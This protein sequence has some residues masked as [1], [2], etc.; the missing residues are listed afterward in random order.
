MY[1]NNQSEDPN[2][3]LFETGFR[4]GPFAVIT[5]VILIFGGMGQ[6]LDAQLGQNQ[7]EAVEL[8]NGMRIIGRIGSL[9]E[10]GATNVSVSSQSTSYGIVLVEDEL[11]DTFFSR[12]NVANI[13]P[14]DRQETK[15]EIWQHVHE[16][17]ANNTAVG[18]IMG[19]GAFDKFGR[20]TITTMT[21]RGPETVLQGI[22][23]ISPRYV[24]LEGLVN[25]GEGREEQWDMR[26]AL[27]SVPVQV[28]EDV[29]HLQIKDRD[30]ANERMRLVDFFAQAQKFSHAERELMAIRRDFPGLRQ[31]L[32]KRSELL[33]GQVARQM[34][35]EA[36]LRAD[37]GQTGIAGQLIAPLL[38][39]TDLSG[40]VLA[41]VFQTRD[42]LLAEVAG[43]DTARQQVID[44][45]TRAFAGNEIAGD[46]RV[47][48]ETVVDEIK[49]TLRSTNL[50]RLAT[51]ARLADDP[52][53][54]DSQKLSLAITGWIVGAG[55][56]NDNP[57]VAQSLVQARTLVAEY[58]QTTRSD[59]R[60]E[61][62]A[63]LET[64]ES[65]A[66]K[67]I[68]LI[69][70]HILPPLAP[71][72]SETTSD[73]PM[74]INI[75]FG[76]PPMKASYLIQLPPE[77][78][79]W[80]NYPCIVTLG[81]STDSQTTPE[82]QIDW[83]C[84][85]MLERFGIRNGHASRHGYIVIAPRWT[86]PSQLS[87]EYSQKE[88]AIVLK[89]L[90][91]AMR[92][93]SIDP[94]RV[95]LTGH[96]DGGTAAWDIGQSHPEHWAGVI[97]I[98][99]RAGKYIN[100]TFEN[101]KLH[102]SWYFINGGRDFISRDLNANVWNKRM[103]TREYQT[104]IVLIRGRGAEKFGDELPNLFQWMSV[105]RR[106]PAIETFECST[107]R[108]WNNNFWWLELDL[109]DNPKMVAPE[110]N[111]DVATKDDWSV[112][113]ERKI[114]QNTLK[115]RGIRSNTAAAVWMSPEIVDFAK[116]IKIENVGRNFSG[117]VKPSR[118]IILEDARTRGDRQHAWWARVRY[119]NSNWTV[120]E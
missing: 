56:A 88:Q 52:Q 89:S 72:L 65:G 15:F 110:V 111:W 58:L 25:Q 75:E 99:A 3:P 90:R 79:P 9:K 50:D 14:F 80:R 30:N 54:T 57:G 13:S 66:V 16:G 51:F 38:S 35:D 22:T 27:N 106:Q 118:R 42:E 77:Y 29:L 70:K 78:D 104:I 49:G 120:D 12:F 119:V 113:G 61:I 114:E 46:I 115:V 21:S 71:S 32:E 63:E 8:G 82:S 76:S 45:A 47:V 1:C 23:E 112:S 86:R 18:E 83:W 19:I 91:D 69:L 93:F 92:R 10:M 41:D 37:A 64:Q 60:T 43:V 102:S 11:R 85:P 81:A 94:D 44:V 101:G 33:S 7:L 84:G 67:Y 103:L 40:A 36:R 95:F 6:R 5:S 74:E 28:L 68:D 62:L 39:R 117:E 98:S 96:F 100:H 34:L 26:I 87:Y 55:N 4:T 97:P 2:R 17:D 31:E 53:Q 24:R 107:L 20:R 108:P 116:D 59:R 105:L 48:F 109:N 73:K